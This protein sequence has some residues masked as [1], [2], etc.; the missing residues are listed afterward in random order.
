[1]KFS[2]F[3]AAL[4]YLSSREVDC[5]EEVLNFF[6]IDGD[7]PVLLTTSAEQPDP[8]QIRVNAHALIHHL[9]KPDS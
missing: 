1:M 2:D 4:D 6:Y 7:T 8:G 5:N 9:L 3:R